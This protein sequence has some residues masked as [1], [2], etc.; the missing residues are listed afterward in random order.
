[1]MAAAGSLKKLLAA[2]SCL[3]CLTISVPPVAAV[4][5]A[6]SSS[7]AGAE[8][9][10]PASKA[11]SGSGQRRDRLTSRSDDVDVASSVAALQALV[12]QQATVM[13]GLQS[14]LQAEKTR[15]DVLQ[16]QVS[17]L[18]ERLAVTSKPGWAD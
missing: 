7:I 9:A 17:A 5:A 13:Q 8:P 12:E 15:V 10:R 14:G 1:M 3:L 2:L 6:T 18:T 16:R 4:S 11:G